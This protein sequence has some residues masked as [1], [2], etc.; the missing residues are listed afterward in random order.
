[1]TRLLELLKVDPWRFNFLGEH[2]SFAQP[3]YFWLCLVGVLV[4]TVALV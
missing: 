3:T 1:V 2:V 4:G